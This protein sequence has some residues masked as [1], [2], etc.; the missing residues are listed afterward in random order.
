MSEITEPPL[1]IAAAS[2]APRTR[3]TSY[4]EPYASQMAKREKRQLG[5]LFGLKNFGVNLTR[6]APGGISS[7]LHRHTRQDEFIYII[8]GQPT[9]VTDR[10]EVVLTPGMCAGFPA[11]GVAHQLVNATGADVVYL[12]IGDR[13]PGDQG[14]YPN[15]DIIA[16]FVPG[17]GWQYTHK[18]GTPY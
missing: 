9:P 14:I 3:P 13:T 7:I 8:E 11:A 1:A 4:P 10:G 17:G 16:N 15:D 6:I 2:V 12:E 5:D 18:D